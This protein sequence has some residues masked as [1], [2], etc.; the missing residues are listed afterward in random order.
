M[1]E[2]F[3]YGAQTLP[4]KQLSQSGRT[5]YIARERENIQTGTQA[6][7]QAGRQTR[8]KASTTQQA[9]RLTDRVMV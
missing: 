7:T 6:C 2:H 4:H 8:R 9:D 1:T 3:K 5:Q